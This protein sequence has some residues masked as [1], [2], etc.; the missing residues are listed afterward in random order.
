MTQTK[1]KPTSFVHHGKEKTAPSMI[2][3]SIIEQSKNEEELAFRIATAIRWERDEC[4]RLNKIIKGLK[5][6]SEVPSE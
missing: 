4:A 2:A 1:K 3:E 5:E 6:K